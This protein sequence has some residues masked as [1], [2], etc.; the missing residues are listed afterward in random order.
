M[1]VTFEG[2]EGS[3]KSTQ[4]SLISKWFNTLAVDHIL[5]KEPGTPMVGTC[6]KIRELILNPQND[7]SRR[8]EF[9][10]YLADRAEH[11]FVFSSHSM[12]F[13]GYDMLKNKQGSVQLLY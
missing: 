8:T 9:F 11:Y 6:K 13:P 10:L 1:F 5:T 3:S 12:R 4:A 7:I 2:V